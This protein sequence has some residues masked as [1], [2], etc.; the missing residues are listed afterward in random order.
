MM[1]LDWIAVLAAPINMWVASIR[2]QLTLLP[3]IIVSCLSFKGVTMKLCVVLGLV[4]IACGAGNVVNAQI[5][6]SVGATA[7][8]TITNFESFESYGN[9]SP[10]NPFSS[11]AGFD[12]DLPSGGGVFITLAPGLSLP[13]TTLYQNGGAFSMT[14]IRLTSGANMSAVELDVGNGWGSVSQEVYFRAYDNGLWTGDQFSF[15]GVPVGLFTIEALGA[16]TF[17][18]VRVQAFNNG[19]GH[20][21]SETQFGAAEIDNVHAYTTA[22]P[23][24]SSIAALSVFGLIGAVVYLRRRKK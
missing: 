4:A 16:S 9:S 6:A 5:V 19:Y 2:V 10:G 1:R 20:I 21:S 23:E 22:I 14:S 8:G 13:T 7:T 15:F 18:E 17:D 12:F 24:P 3:L 11:P